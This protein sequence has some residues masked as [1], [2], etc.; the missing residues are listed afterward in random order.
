MGNSS[1]IRIGIINTDVRD[2][3]VNNGLKTVVE[4]YKGSWGINQHFTV[5]G[6]KVDFEEYKEKFTAEPVKIYLQRD[7]GS[8]VA[9]ENNFLNFYAENISGDH[10][11]SYID[12]V[13]GKNFIEYIIKD[14]FQIQP[15][16][17]LHEDRDYGLNFNKEISEILNTVNFRKKSFVS[18]YGWAIN[19]GQSRPYWAMNNR[20]IEKEVSKI[21]SNKNIKNKN[22]YVYTIKL[23][24]KYTKE[25]WYYIGL[26]KNPYNRLENHLTKNYKCTTNEILLC[27]VVDIEACE[28]RKHAK[29]REREKFFEIVQEKETENVLGGR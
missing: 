15:P 12:T 11:Y 25:V 29:K 17:F 28:N 19:I 18:Q 21:I 1:W 2:K 9:K 16:H 10:T 4:T 20:K 13:E 26:S 22:Q 24:D 27:D 14:K 3:F 23:R 7:V 5:C 6:V 8:D